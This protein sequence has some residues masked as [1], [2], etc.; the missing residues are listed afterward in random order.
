MFLKQHLEE[1]V[2]EFGNYQKTL[3][4]N[5]KRVEPTEDGPMKSMIPNTDFASE[6]ASNPI[7]ELEANE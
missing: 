7:D 1:R 4:E 3:K 2:L 5:E 6:Q